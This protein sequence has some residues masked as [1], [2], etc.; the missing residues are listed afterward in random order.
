MKENNDN[1]PA[2]SKWGAKLFYTTL[3]AILIFFWWLLIYSHGI[4]PIHH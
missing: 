3:V 2:P 1:K 4:T